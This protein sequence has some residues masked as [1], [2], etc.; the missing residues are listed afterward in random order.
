[1]GVKPLAQQFSL[2]IAGVPI[3]KRRFIRPPSPP[4]EEQSSA[5]VENDSIQKAGSPSQESATS[6]NSVAASSCGLSDPNKNFIPEENKTSPDNNVQTNT[7]DNSR[8]KIERLSLSIQSDSLSKFDNEEKLV[9]AV[10]SSDSLINSV[11]PELNLAP[12]KAPEISVHK[13]THRQQ[14]AEGKCKSKISTLPGNPELSLGL[15]ELHV[16]AF[17]HYSNDGSS[18]SHGNVEP[19][20]LNLSLSK[21]ESGTRC[22]L[23]N[24]QVKTDSTNICAD[25]SNWDLNT[26]MD[27]WED[28]VGNVA[29]GQVTTDGSNTFGVT[30][31][32]KPVM[33]TTGMVGAGITTEKQLLG[34]RECRSSF[35]RTLLESSPVLNSDDSLHLRLSPSFFPVNTSQ[36]PPRSSANKN[37]SDI[38]TI[39][40]GKGCS[41]VGNVN[42]VNSRTIKSEPFD[43]SLKHD[44]RGTKVNSMGSLDSAVKHELVEKFSQ[45]APGSSNFGPRKLVDPKTIKVEPV[46]SA[47]PRTLET[48]E[49]TSCQSDKQVLPGEDIRGQP[50]FSTNKQVLQ[51][52]DTRGQPT[53]STDNQEQEG[54][55]TMAKQPCLTEFSMSG[56]ASENLEHASR[57]EEAHLSKDV[58]KEACESAGQIA[59]EMVS[60]PLGQSCNEPNVSVTPDTAVMEDK[61]ADNLEECELKFTDELPLDSHGNGEGPVSDEEKI[62]LSGDML[63]EDSYG[64]EYE[65]DGNSVSMDIDE[66]RQEQDDYEDGEVR[67]P[68]LHAAA[69]GAICEK[70]D[71]ASHDDSDNK[72]ANLA[73]LPGDDHPILTH[74]EENNTKREDPVETNEDTVKESIDTPLD[75]KIVE[76][77]DKDASVEESSA[78]EMPSSGG[79]NKM[80]CRKEPIDIS[81]NEDALMEQGTQQ[82]SDQPTSGDQGT[83]STLAQ[84]SDDHVKMNDVEKDDPALRKEEASV[85]GDDA[86]KDVNN[87]GNRSRI[88]NLSRASNMLSPGKTRSISGRPLPSRTGRERLPDVPLEGDK[89]HP[90]GR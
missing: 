64:S 6:N 43:E 17:K 51:G 22:R 82:S 5:L 12:N 20:S 40:L 16:S 62:N 49:G 61:V 23:D 69:E 80:A 3:K 30:H 21:G 14:I 7:N 63:E 8:A 47:N 70:K 73:E 55:D 83:F 27:A 34:E 57:A 90:R 24:V 84:D 4:P 66:E 68:Q 39:S 26:T 29:A 11:K 53:C 78:V 19:I 58:P 32:I 41:S 35:P 86:A 36:E 37:S 13:E 77:A 88:I 50:P 54:Q 45:E 42:M 89:L 9:A 85:N 67:E 10:K 87:G 65:S 48:I 75:G 28:S 74:V 46:S 44:L 15:T 1:M 38:S 25:R 59:S 71:D 60:P 81:A 18:Q 52:Q 79:D 72:K 76:D 56:K 33:S 2:N 31:G